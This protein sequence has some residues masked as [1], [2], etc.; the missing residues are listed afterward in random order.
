MG[1][2]EAEQEIINQLQTSENAHLSGEIERKI[3]EEIDSTR[4]Q[5][6]VKAENILKQFG[7]YKNSHSI[8]E[9]ELLINFGW[10]D[11]LSYRQTPPIRFESTKANVWLMQRE[12]D[13]MP[14]EP[15]GFGDVHIVIK[16]DGEEPMSLFIIDT[17]QAKNIV[18]KELKTPKQFSGL[19]N[20]LDFYQL[21]VSK[22]KPATAAKN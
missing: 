1:Q 20:V 21:A 2:K 8:T 6:L 10:S 7:K 18:G 3:R 19:T 9:A 5:T 11:P 15:Q 12:V 13:T 17:I 16:K 4:K 22:L 14:S